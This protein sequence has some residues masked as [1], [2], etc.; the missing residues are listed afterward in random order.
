[1]FEDVS[2]YEYNGAA[3]NLN[4]GANAEQVHGIRVSADY[5][6]LLGAPI[7]QGRAFAV[8]EDRPN[9][10]QVVVLSHGL[11]QRDFGSDP[12]IVGN[13]ISLNGAKYIVVGIAG[14]SFDTGP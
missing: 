8:D 11:W 10:G 12:M 7:V 3:L 9:G 6:H 2:A 5:F 14:A 4:S 1:M 13:S